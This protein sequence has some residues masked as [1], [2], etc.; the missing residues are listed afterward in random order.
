MEKNIPKTFAHSLFPFIFA[1]PIS[2]FETPGN[3]E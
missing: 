1:A 3:W 2:S